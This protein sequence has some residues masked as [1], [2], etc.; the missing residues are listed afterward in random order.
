MRKVFFLGALLGALAAS[1]ASAATIDP[2]KMMAS[3][4]VISLG[5]LNASANTK[6]TAYVGGNLSSNGY[7]VN[8]NQLSDGTV[9][10]ITGSLVVGGNV[11]GSN[12]NVQ[13]GA[14]RIGGSQNAI[15]NQN[16]TG[17]IETGVSDIPTEDV[18]RAFQTL[19]R[20][21]SRRSDTPD[22]IV[23]SSD[24][25]SLSVTSGAAGS[26]GFALINSSAALVTHGTF[27]GVTSVNGS[28]ANVPTIVNISGE[29]VRIGANF[30]QTLSN[31]LFNFYEA[32]TLH[33]AAAFN[34]SILAPFAHVTST[35]GGTNG[36]VVAGS[37]YQQNEF[38]PID[39]SR[40]F[41]GTLPPMTQPSQVP[42]PASVWLLIMALG[43][44]GVAARKRA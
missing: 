5:D 23:Y 18:T 9:G 3:F 13:T 16:G 19:S 41:D 21:L 17:S 25:N 11:S 33:I 30:N 44:L 36:V 28:R 15:I 12:V 38:R 7:D 31:V 2:A 6:G 40:L 24:H 43:G 14:V 26:E 4:N 10:S 22:A 37:L 27:K 1:G 8:L 35:G 29:T 42:L 20:D 32:K 39:D 34:F